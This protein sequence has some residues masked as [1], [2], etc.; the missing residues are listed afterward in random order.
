MVTRASVI[1]I[2]T[3]DPVTGTGVEG[4]PLALPATTGGIARMNSL[5]PVSGVGTA[6]PEGLAVSP[7]GAIWS[8]LSTAPT[9]PSWSTS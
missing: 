3:V 8:S 7:D 9:A 4:T 5:P 1:H 6:Q 2:F